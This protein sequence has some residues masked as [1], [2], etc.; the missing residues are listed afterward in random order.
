R[1]REIM[2]DA[3]II[4]KQM[5]FDV[6]SAA[7]FDLGSYHYIIDA[8]DSLSPKV[9]LIIRAHES[10]AKIFTA[11]GASG[12]IDPTRIMVGSLWDSH[13]CRFGKL[14]RKRL[15]RRKFCGEVT[16]VYSPE[17]GVLFPEENV[18]V[19]ERCTSKKQINGSAV[20]VTG[21]F[22]FFLAGLVVQDVVR[23][24]NVPVKE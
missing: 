18:C 7:Q 3:N 8:I 6:F 12:K 4:E 14:V 9:E 5:V 16:C 21:T 15:R 1:L 19:H 10:G 23:R 20:H 2:P 22:G 13:D 24:A 11:L 17:E